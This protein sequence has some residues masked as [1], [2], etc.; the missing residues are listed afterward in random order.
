MPR[1]NQN[2]LLVLWE[3]EKWQQF[4]GYSLSH[5]SITRVAEVCTT[6]WNNNK[7][8]IWTTLIFSHLSYI[9]EILQFQN[10]KYFSWKTGESWVH[11]ICSTKVKF[12]T[13]V[14]IFKRK[15]F[16]YWNSILSFF[17]NN[18]GQNKKERTF[19]IMW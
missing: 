1:A 17:S 4:F 16:I 6:S 12:P 3:V 10:V 14:T 7:Y 8:V 15:L 11:S 9:W 2:F 13:K 19:K 18:L 5:S